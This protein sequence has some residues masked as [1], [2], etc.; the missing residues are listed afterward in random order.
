MTIEKLKRDLAS[1]YA[2]IDRML[3]RQE[4]DP[5]LPL[6]QEQAARLEL[7]LTEEEGKAR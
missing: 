3:E 5:T 1:V 6:L 4:M 2:Q 7:I